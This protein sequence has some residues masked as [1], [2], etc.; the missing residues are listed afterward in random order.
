MNYDKLFKEMNLSYTQAS[1]ILENIKMYRKIISSLDKKIGVQENEVLD[2]VW[3][4]PY[5]NVKYYNNLPKERDLKLRKFK[6][7]IAF[8]LNQRQKNIIKNLNYRLNAK[9]NLKVMYLATEKY[10]KITPIATEAS[11]ES[12]SDILVKIIVGKKIT[13]KQI[14]SINNLLFKSINKI[15]TINLLIKNIKGNCNHCK[16]LKE[17]EDKLKSSQDKIKSITVNT[18]KTIKEILGD[19]VYANIITEYKNESTNSIIEKILFSRKIETAL[20]RIYSP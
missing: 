19:E 4:I 16:L 20:K 3:N 12:A 2:T 17:E 11:I 1:S 13:P 7:K 10:L 8:I 14:I 18:C 6:N 5:D 9:I 15:D